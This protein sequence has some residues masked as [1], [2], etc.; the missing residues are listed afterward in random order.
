MALSKILCVDLDGTFIKTDMLYESFFYSFFRNPL[1]LFLSI[2]WL[3]VGGKAKLKE[4]LAQRYCFTA[5]NIPTNKSVI[6]LIVNKKLLGYKIYL[7]SASY[8]N[9]VSS[10][11]NAYSD[12]FDGCFATSDVNLSSQRK[13]QF[14]NNKFGKENYEYVGNSKDD[15][16][17]WN[18]CAYAYYVYNNKSILGKISVK[19]ELLTCASL[20][21]GPF[22]FFRIV[23][24]QLRCHQWAKNALI[25]VPVLSC[26]QILS[27]HS[28]LMVAIGILAF[29]LIASSVYIINDIIDLDNDRAH[30]T[31]SKRPIAS[32]KLTLIQAVLLLA[33][34][35]TTGILLA[36]IVS[37]QF[38]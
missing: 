9:I 20:K 3:I 24:K 7:V 6:D 8:E 37:S 12:L 2:F 23:I 27:V 26:A 28:Y 21:R 13:A 32:C 11:F 29:S 16:V 4:K 31:K 10:F 34:T 14:L 1:V 25:A 38:L 15:I 19:K 18:N 17:V 36:T 22:E 30:Q 33:C 5:K 35:L